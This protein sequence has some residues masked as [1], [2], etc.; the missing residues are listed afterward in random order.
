MRT[1]IAAWTMLGAL[2]A[3]AGPPGD[4]RDMG[5]GRHERGEGQGQSSGNRVLYTVR[6]LSSLGGTS[7][8]GNGL[9]ANGWVTGSSNLA[10]DTA[11]HATI[12]IRG[13]LVDLGT[14]GGPNS[15]VAWP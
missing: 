9:T 15:N 1:W 8:A 11:S 6:N 10:G 12:W 13:F 14:L 4:G 5:M 3:H 7:S 2:A